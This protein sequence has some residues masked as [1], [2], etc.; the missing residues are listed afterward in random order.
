MMTSAL[1]LILAILLL[2]GLIAALGD[3]LGTKIGKARLRIFNLRPKQTAIL[4]TVVTGVLISASTL[5]ILFALSKS[6]R[7]GI[8]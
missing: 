4:V 7:Q 6:L 5:G 3:R 2:G 8:F 1:V